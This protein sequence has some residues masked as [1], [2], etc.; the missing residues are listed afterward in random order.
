[1]LRPIKNHP[2]AGEDSKPTRHWVKDHGLLL[3]NAGL[4]VVFLGGMI[5]SGAATY[6]EEQQAHG[7]P[8]TGISDFLTSGSFWE[9]VFENWESEF[10]QMAMYVV[11]TVFLFQR[12]SSESKPVDK[13]APQDQDPRAA[14]KSAKTPWPVKRGGWVL[15]V[16]E[17]SLSG[18]LGLLFLFSFTMHAVGGTAAYNEEQLSHGLPEIST[19]EYMASSQFWF[20]SFQNWQSEFLAV[21]VLVGASVYLRERGSPESKP[22]AEPHHETGA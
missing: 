22:V 13:E 1:M 2:P 20:E 12:G 5:I 19:W 8:A 21:A 17:H 3:V 4:F 15:K 11:L 10:L 6:S 9:A 16:Y 7:Q 18:L 14:E